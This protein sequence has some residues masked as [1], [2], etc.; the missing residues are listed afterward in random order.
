MNIKSHAAC[1]LFVR[2]LFALLGC[3]PIGAARSQGLTASDAQIK[4]A[5]VYNVAKFVE[6]PPPS[7]TS[8]AAHLQLC[9]AG[10]GPL[11]NLLSELDGKTVQGRQLNVQLHA[12]SFDPIACHIVFFATGAA[13]PPADVLKALKGLAVLT[14]SDIGGFVEQGGI[15][16]LVLGDGRLQFDVNLSAAQ[17]G[18]LRLSVQLLKLARN[19]KGTPK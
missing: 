8:P 7:F 18:N 16:E 14:V 4:A 5:F 1:R 15:L 10:R 11:P 17:Q 19:A 13:S 2:I 9:V 3:G 6:W 12:S